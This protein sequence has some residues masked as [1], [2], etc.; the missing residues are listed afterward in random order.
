MDTERE[1]L[2]LS[3][4][5]EVQA[6]CQRHGLG[7]EVVD[8]RWGVREADVSDHTMTELCLEEL[9]RCQETSIG[10][11][12]V[13]LL[14]D[15]Y[16]PCPVPGLIEER[17]WEALAAS[18]R[19]RP[20][21]LELVARR[22]QRD[23]NAVP[24]TCVLQ[25]PDVGEARGP[26][27]AS[28]ASV[29]QA[30]ALEARRL[31]L[32]SQEQWHRYHR[33]VLEW[34]L[35]VGVLRPGA[36]ARG[37][38]VFLREIRDLDKHMLDEC[39]LL[40]LDRLPD[41]CPDTGARGLLQRLKER[42]AEAH[43]EI[44]QAHPLPWSRDLLNPK[45]K[46]HA[47]YLRGLGEQFVASAHHQILAGL[48]ARGAAPRDQA[49]LFEELRVHQRRQAA[50]AAAPLC[51]RQEL[52]A[53][54]GRRL[55]DG[56]RR[57]HP[58]LVLFGAPGVGKTALLCALA[59]A[60]PGLL[61]RKAVTAL[62]VLGA[63]WS[64]VDP[65]A[66]PRSLALQL[67]LAFGLPPPPGPVLARRGRLAQFLQA[68]LH[69]AARR[70]CESLVLVLDGVDAL[71][72]L[73]PGRD[74]LPWLPARC[75]PR[76]H[77]VLSACSGGRRPPRHALDALRAKIRDADAFVEVPPLAAGPGQD[78]V[79][80]L[81]AAAGR[82]LS[83]AQRAALWAWLPD[84]GHPGRLRLA[85]EE[86]RRW[87]SFTV[88]APL[89]ST[90]E[91]ATHHLCA[92]LEDAHGRLLVSHVLGYIAAS[93]FGLS[94]AELKD[95][96]SLDDA[97]LCEVYRAWTPPSRRLL[98]FP[99]LLWVRLRRDLGL[100]L[101]RRPADGGQLLTLAHRQLAEVV[102]VRYLSEPERAQRHSILADF[103]SGAWSQGTKK[104]ITL[105]LVGVPL[106]L[107][108]KVAPQPLWFSDSVANERR[109]QELP[110]H[111][112]LAGR[113]REL[114]QDLLGNVSW[115]V[116]RALSGGAE[117][118][119]DDLDLC[120]QHLRCPEV[121]LIREA[122]R[123]SRPALELRGTEK[124]TLYTELLA[125]L[126]FFSKS[127]P[128]LVGQLC[129]QAQSWLRACP[130]PVL[131]PLAGFLQPPGGPLQATLTGC[132]KGITAVAWSQ[133]QRLLVLGT[134]D[135][136]VAVWHVEEERP[137]HFLPAHSG[138]VWCVRVFAQGTRAVSAS[139]DR[140][141]RLWGLLSGQ[142]QLSIWD[143]GSANST[144]P[145][146]R[147]LHV[148]E[149]KQVLYL[150][151]G[152]KISAWALDTAA[153]LFRVL[154]EASDPWL[155]AAWLAAPTRLLTVSQA[156]VVSVWSAASGAL[157]GKQRL[158]SVRGETPT[159]AAPLHKQGTVVAGFSNGSVSL[160]SSKGDRLLEKLPKAVGLVEVSEDGSLLAAGFG[161]SVRIFLAN[162]QGFQRFLATDLQH[163]DAVETA[164]FGPKNNL[165]V[166]A[167]RDALIQVWSLSEQGTLLGL[168]DGVG[169]PLGTLVRAGALVVGAS[170]WSS[171]FRAWDVSRAR[172]RGACAPFPDRTG[173]TAVS[174]N[175]SYVYFPG[176]GEKNQV[177]IWDLAEG[178]ARGALDTSSEV[179]CLEVAEQTKLLFA[180]LLSG[181]VLVFP[182][183]STLDVLCIPPPEA[184][185][186][187][188]CMALSKE[189]ERLAVAYD[190][191]VLVL[192][193][194]PGDPCPV[195]DGPTFT[196]YTQL[197]DTIATV[198][199]LADCRVAYGMTHGDL[200]LYECASSKVCPLEAH[201]SRVSCV[202][203][204]HGGQLAVSGSEE[205]LLCLW[206]LGTCQ[207]KLE[208]SYMGSIIRGVQCVCFSQD[209][210]YLFSAWRDGSVL[211]WRALDGSLLAVQFVHA[212]VNRIIPTANGFLAPTRQGRLI[213]MRFQCPAASASPQDAL[214]NFQKAVW[215]V[216]TRRREELAAGA[217]SAQ[218]PGSEAPENETNPNKRSQVCLLL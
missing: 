97:L 30:G 34:E 134:H 36:A 160:I 28:L 151:S 200:F 104:L 41:G 113:T 19:A 73:G 116:C 168:L 165:I 12:F 174:H 67:S 11:T 145:Q 139:T 109:L 100:C 58:P 8:L 3:A 210:K 32:L 202:E 103:F 129:Q 169:A 107:D 216:K 35:E 176:V 120:A 190:N 170:R 172:Q 2:L 65:G 204:S 43:P 156:C 72:G 75:P 5:P 110:R 186:A 29:L 83:P 98:R 37:V 218:D 56:E 153:L 189:E 143:G 85:F 138:E 59:G 81:L 51:G 136:V 171:T 215:M 173:L 179:R 206:D 128:A 82:T 187:V 182:L 76:V 20:R 53:R 159:C 181:A 118:L 55:R 40:A 102:S 106:S 163:E 144:E 214:Q 1:A 60:A 64:S 178:A 112:L 130:H 117:A 69:A 46:A 148:D 203:V 45:N 57:A 27:E 14:G 49:G 80:G 13:A 115:L 213:R 184:R 39:A 142:Q 47:R 180:G 166:T 48:G 84:C 94:E 62:R 193:V 10:P 132:H 108:R 44:L 195:V 70:D 188:N 197:P 52:L 6:F 4:C 119:L 87:A 50:E 205:G 54:L 68:L 96:L 158:S 26:E 131:V 71:D 9:S 141:L 185:K 24:P 101:A 155:C 99:P 31:G 135:G 133:E 114:R 146:T 217:G 15:R 127:H 95:V 22:F 61:G 17:E 89:A 212:V 90:A 105:P 7:F 207:C 79:R 126:L 152:S 161:K 149:A 91:E 183:N 196:F 111:L 88:P 93:R 121:G 74:P 177:T 150:A 125:R 194:G 199:V 191:M 16:G 63:S 167:S 140:T 66:L 123:L 122:V 154:G 25:E 162:A 164:V 42:L 18:L 201:A 38:T 192:G 92:R 137:V 211:V 33:S 175:G 147:S 23:E 124:S 198:A 208:M 209:D 157:Q 86:A 78:L 77:V 21:D